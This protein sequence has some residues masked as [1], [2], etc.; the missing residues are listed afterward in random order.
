[1]IIH[2]VGKRIAFSREPETPVQ[3]QDFFRARMIEHA[4]SPVH[5]FNEH[6]NVM[7]VLQQ[8]GDGQLDFQ[9]GG[10]ELA[11]LFWRDHA[12][13]STPGAFFVFQLSTA[14]PDDILYVMIKYDYRAVVELS[15]QDGQNV[16]REIIQAFVKEK[17]AVQKFCIARYRNGQ[18]EPAVSATDRMGEAPDL[19]DYFETFLGVSRAR[20]I[21][22][23]SARLNEAMRSSLQAVRDHLP[24]RNVGAALARAKQS[25]QGRGVVTNDD[26]VDAVLHGANRPDDEDLVSRIER[27]T[28]SKLRSS[29][30]TDVDFRPDPATLQVAPRH[31]VK[32]A[33]GTRIEYQEAELGRTIFRDDTPDGTT[34]TIRTRH[35]LVED[36]TV[37]IRPG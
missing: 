14:L 26:I 13:Q 28:R 5:Q 9:G 27:V 8:M 24:E 6:S 30:L 33:E 1:M 15:Q 20:T 29:N 25:L 32:T 12:P 11:R 7:P 10:Q 21:Q 34:F 31:R 23:L 37:T 16:L 18:I 2:L 19:T 36:D 4:S 22:E 3:Q 17:R 35:Q